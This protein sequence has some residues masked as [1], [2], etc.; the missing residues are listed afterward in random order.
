MARNVVKLYSTQEEKQ[1]FLTK[2]GMGTLHPLSI[3]YSSTLSV[4]GQLLDARF[5]AQ[6]DL[7]SLQGIVGDDNIF[8]VAVYDGK[9]KKQ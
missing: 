8:F 7:L 2:L 6:I 1:E 9:E 4:D 3:H 5:H